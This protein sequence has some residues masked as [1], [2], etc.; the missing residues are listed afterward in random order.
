MARPLSS[1]KQGCLLP[2]RSGCRSPHPVCCASLLLQLYTL[3]GKYG[4][5]RQ[6]RLGNSKETRGTAYVVYEDIFDAKTAVDHLSGF[7][8]Q[9]GADAGT[10]T[11]TP[12]RM[13]P[14]ALGPRCCSS[15]RVATRWRLPAGCDVA[16]PPRLRTLPAARA[17]A[18]VSFRR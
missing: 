18:G 16:A 11:R 12:C 14:P 6:I 7:N 4:A 1:P 8:V 5:I 17:P 2:H 15:G 10:T 9:V 13:R 3:F